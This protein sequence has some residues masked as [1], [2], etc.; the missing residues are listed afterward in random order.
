MKS[1][2]DLRDKLTN[3]RHFVLLF[4]GKRIVPDAHA[5]AF[6]GVGYLLRFG[7]G[8]EVAASFEVFIEP[9]KVIG[10]LQPCEMQKFI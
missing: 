9:E 7:I 10:I 1:G 3:P 2:L 5:D 8:F 6:E 4:G